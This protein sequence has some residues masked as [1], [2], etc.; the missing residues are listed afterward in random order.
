MTMILSVESGI[1]G[2]DEN[3]YIAGV[4]AN[5]VAE[6]TCIEGAGEQELPVQ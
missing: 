2:P 3:P 5:E 4:T 1:N 6:Y